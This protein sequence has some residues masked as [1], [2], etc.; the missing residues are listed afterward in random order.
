LFLLSNLRAP[1]PA[2]ARLRQRFAW[3]L[4]AMNL[5]AGLIFIA[6]TIAMVVTGPPRLRRGLAA[7]R[8]ARAG[9][10]RFRFADRRA[11]VQAFESVEFR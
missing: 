7:I 5:A 1:G 8:I 10:L 4:A 2:L 6:F 3:T 11:A 9:G